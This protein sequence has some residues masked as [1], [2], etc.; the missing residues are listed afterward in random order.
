MWP[1]KKRR[2][3][4]QEAHAKILKTGGVI[5]GDANTFYGVN[6]YGHPITDADL[7]PI[8]AF[9]EV[10][11]LDI[12][13]SLVTDAGLKSLRS[14]RNLGLLYMEDVQVGDEGL[15]NLAGLRRLQVLDLSGTSVTDDGL[16]H[17]VR[18]NKLECL[19]L[20][21]A[22]ITDLAVPHLKRLIG[23]RVLLVDPRGL[24]P[25]AMADLQ[26]TIPSL[27]INPAEDEAARD[28]YDPELWPQ[29]P[30]CAGDL[31][32]VNFNL[33]T[34][35]A[36]CPHC[37]HPLWEFPEV[38]EPPPFG[39]YER[40]LWGAVAVAS[41]HV[42]WLNDRSPLAAILWLLGVLAFGQLLL[43]PVFRWVHDIVNQRKWFWL[44]V[45]CGWGLVAGLPVGIMAGVL[46]PYLV[47]CGIPSWM[48]GIVGLIAGPVFAAVEGVTLAS[49]LCGGFW[50]ATGKNFAR[51]L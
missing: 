51:D 41:M 6:F 4:R 14:L 50:L 2:Q 48:G 33:L 30:M 22:R 32:D 36:V 5:G 15:A 26:A 19:Y 18:L 20:S 49:I 12:H 7:A 10:D 11:H 17:L 44:A 34:D 38:P 29:C 27:R 1:W 39:R 24:S 25:S 21:R 43:P 31:S 35:D 8:A 46:V 3:R 9:P 37:E 42:V 40:M 45:I 28:E 13:Q 23:L 47:P 16:R